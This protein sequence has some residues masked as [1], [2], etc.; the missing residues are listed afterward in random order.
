MLKSVMNVLMVP[1][2]GFA[3]LIA[4]SHAD[5]IPPDL[6]DPAPY[7]TCANNSNNDYCS[8]E[9]KSKACKDPATGLVGICWWDTN[10]TNCD[11]D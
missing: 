9:T 3:L 2:L 10:S 4:V 7:V 11:C 5:V 8:D 6:E 1:V